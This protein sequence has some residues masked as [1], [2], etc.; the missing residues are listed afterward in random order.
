MGR[1]PFWGPRNALAWSKGQSLVDG[2]YLHT[3]QTQLHTQKQKHFQSS[4]AMNL[5]KSLELSEG[6]FREPVAIYRA[7]ILSLESDCQTRFT[8]SLIINYIPRIHISN[9]FVDGHI[10]GVILRNSLP[11]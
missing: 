1:A 3:S 7:E 11:S 4:F 5:E 2:F 6:K 8:E 9:I 10:P